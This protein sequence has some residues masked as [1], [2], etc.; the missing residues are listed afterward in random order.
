[1]L[2]RLYTGIL[3]TV[4]TAVGIVMVVLVVST[5]RADAGRPTPRTLTPCR[6]F[7]G[8]TVRIGYDSRPGQVLDPAER[9]AQMARTTAASVRGTLRHS[10]D[11]NSYVYNATDLRAIVIA[12]GSG[13][14]SVLSF[15]DGDSARSRPMSMLECVP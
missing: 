14:A 3:W 11:G 1:M 15:E 4:A 7:Q 5:S 8:F 10:R 6:E 9:A 13:R 2:E 12:D